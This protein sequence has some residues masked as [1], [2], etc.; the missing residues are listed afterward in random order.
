MNDHL[1][2]VRQVAAYLQVS[3]RSVRRMIR[4]GKLKVVRLGRCV[5]VSGG[6]VSAL[7]E[8]PVRNS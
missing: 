3:E 7:L 5:R 8:N 2:T 1:L 6:A 4:D